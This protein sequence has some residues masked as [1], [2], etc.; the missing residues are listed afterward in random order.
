M[1]HCPVRG[2]DDRALLYAERLDRVFGIAPSRC[3]LRRC[4]GRGSAWIDPRPTPQSIGRT[5]A[6]Y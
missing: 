6:D 5:Y 3:N 4:G 2:S 1:P